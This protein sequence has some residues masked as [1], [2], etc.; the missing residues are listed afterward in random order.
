MMQPTIEQLVAQHMLI[1]FAGY[2]EL[3]ATFL[4]ELRQGIAGVTLFRHLNVRN[5]AQVRALCTSL[6]AAA[7]AANQPSLLIAADQEAGQLSAIGGLTPLPG[8]MALGA[9]G[10]PELAYQAGT[11]LGRELAA[12][13]ININYA[14]VC[15]VNSNPANPV[16]GVRS[17]GENPAMVAELAAALIAGMQAEGVAATAKHFPGHGDTASDSHFGLA[18]VPHG[19]ERLDDI[20]LPPFRQAINAGVKLVM[21]AHLALPALDEIPG[22]PATLS[23]QVL[24]GL[25][26]KELGFGGLAVSD[27][28]NM[29][30]MAQGELLGLEAVA[31]VRAGI[32]LLL[33]SE[34]LP[35]QARVRASLN[36]AARRGLLDRQ[37][38]HAAFARGLALKNWLAGFAQPEMSAIGCAAHQA[39]ANE[40][41]RR[42]VTLVRDTAR[43]LPL[44][45]GPE[46]R[47][48]VIVPRPSDLTPA[49]TSSYET[50]GLAKALQP[51][52]A[53]IDELVVAPNPSEDEI[54]AARQWASERDL[55]VVGTFNAEAQLGQAA[56]MNAL[57]ATG[58]SLVA[59]ALRLPYDL[60]SYKAAQTYLCTYSIQ[61]PSLAALAAVLF[62][63]Q[64]ALGRLPVNVV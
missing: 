58:A 53:Q 50:I 49:D 14:P 38:M 10:S 64:V 42:S 18:S 47:I 36:L 19:R 20:E 31:A 48:G 52:H 41:A 25:L 55:L 54:A 24:R 15:D 59:V 32:D 9:T 62:G 2:D 60:R 1:A 56:L 29:E 45:P 33:L 40:I 16:I 6:Q 22:L 26:R 37:D 61:P 23:P 51:Y 13:G 28:M 46:T 8:N 3:P 63:E 5:P 39:V 30:A 4:N 57:L 34:H 12:L 43:L 27:A 44:R 21:S 17:F 7:R 11:V 35:S